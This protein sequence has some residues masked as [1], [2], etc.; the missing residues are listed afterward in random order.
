MSADRAATILARFNSAHHDLMWKLRDCAFDA[1]EHLPAGDGWSAAQIGCHVAITN[2][3]MAS[4]LTGEKPMAQ[5]AP[6]DF[7]ESFDPGSVP[8]KLKTLAILEPPQVIGIDAAIERLRTSAHHMSKA[9]AGLTPERG[10][11]YCVSL[12]FGTLSLFELA[13]F[14]AAHVI[15]H[16]VQ[17]Q[18][19]VGKV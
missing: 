19:V 4:V 13:D 11:G 12:P 10:T 3:F 5:P 14:T 16:A 15:R 18:K 1:A 8:A 2:D 7:R 9:I 17:V 6:A